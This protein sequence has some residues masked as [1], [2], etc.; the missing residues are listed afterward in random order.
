MFDWQTFAVALIILCALAY[1]GRRALSRLRSFRAG[2]N[3]NAP[4]CATGCGNCGNEKETT[5]PTNVL[6]QIN[7]KPTTKSHPARR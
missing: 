2:G 3:S 4:A 7:P 5:R 6:V 1:T